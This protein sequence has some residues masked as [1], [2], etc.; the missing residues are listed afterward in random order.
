[1][2]ENLFSSLIPIAEAA[3]SVSQKA[4]T[5]TSFAQ[6]HSEAGA[7]S[8]LGYVVSHIDNWIGG[9]MVIALFYI[10]GKM[11]AKAAKE[12]ILRSRGEEVQESVVVLVERITFLTILFIGITIAFALNGLNFTAVIGA[13]SLGIGFA[14]KDILSNFISGVI[15]LSQDRIRIGDLINIEGI[16]GTIVSIDAR[17]TILQ[18]L[19]GTE[20]V[21][22]NHNMINQTLI[23]YTTNPFRRSEILVGVQY[24]TDLPK[25]VSLIKGV[26]KGYKDIVDKPEP[27]VLIDQFGDSS[28]VIKVFFWAESRKNW[29]VIKSNLANRIKKALDEVGITMPFPIRTLKFDQDDREFLKTM[30]S[31]KKGIVPE[32]LP[33]KTDDM[34]INAV[35]KTKNEP[36]IPYKLEKEVNK[37]NSSNNEAI[38]DLNPLT[39]DPPPVTGVKAQNPTASPPPTHL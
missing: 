26:I 29:L 39:L 27:Q 22:P 18:A 13:L 12:A 23:S 20:V 34:L 5:A 11:G 19:D 32:A 36:N 8:L 2:L 21:I 17:S 4:K 37:Q 10:L 31:L 35:E 30:D 24:S 1:M 7:N 15:I 3:S 14:V 33:P 38:P 28:I 16:I 6:Q 25:A 9:V